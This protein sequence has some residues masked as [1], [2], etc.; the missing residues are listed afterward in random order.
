LRRSGRGSNPPSPVRGLIQVGVDVACSRK[1][2]RL[3]QS[4][5]PAGR[6][7]PTRRILQCVHKYCTVTHLC[8]DLFLSDSRLAENHRFCH[9]GVGYRSSFPHSSRNSQFLSF[10]LPKFELVPFPHLHHALCFHFCSPLASLWLQKVWPYFISG[11]PVISTE[12]KAMVQ[13]K[14][15]KPNRS[16]MS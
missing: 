13:V 3:I 7:Q 10:L 1:K 16:P 9:A 14:A 2:T 6:A 11:Y 8:F 15:P 12:E 4:A 5:Q